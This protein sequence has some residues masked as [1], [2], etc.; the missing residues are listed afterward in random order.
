MIILL[1]AMIA[2]FLIRDRMRGLSRAICALIAMSPSGSRGAID[3]AL[4]ERS[5][6]GVMRVANR[7]DDRVG[8]QMSMC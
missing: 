8:R 2:A 3:W 4:F 5:F 1:F 7:T 6:F